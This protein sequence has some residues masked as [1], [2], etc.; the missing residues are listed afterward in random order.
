MRI[1]VICLGTACR[2][3]PQKRAPRLYYSNRVKRGSGKPK[4]G[5]QVRAV[6]DPR[7]GHVT[8]QARGLDV[9]GL[10]L[11][12]VGARPVPMGRVPEALAGSENTFTVAVAWE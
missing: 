5:G 1:L 8:I 3:P 9:L 12:A 2:Y 10:A 7:D 4:G 6:K 11:A